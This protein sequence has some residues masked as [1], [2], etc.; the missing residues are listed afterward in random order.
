MLNRK[1]QFDS[2]TL[3][4]NIYFRTLCMNILTFDVHCSLSLPAHSQTTVDTPSTLQE[5]SAERHSAEV[6]S[7]LQSK[8][9][10]RVPAGQA[11]SGRF[12]QSGSRSPGLSTQSWQE[13]VREEFTSMCALRQISNAVVKVPNFVTDVK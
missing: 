8:D 1:M 6:E 4:V 9:G 12:P 13:G 7:A 5:T 11:G 10:Q 3:Y 2:F